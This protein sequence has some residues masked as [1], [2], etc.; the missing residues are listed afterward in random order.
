MS[1]KDLFNEGDASYDAVN[2]FIT[3]TKSEQDSHK[4]WINIL[5][6]TVSADNKKWTNV[7]E[8]RNHDNTPFVL[9]QKFLKLVPMQQRFIGN[10]A[11]SFFLLRRTSGS[12]FKHLISLWMFCPEFVSAFIP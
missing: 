1:K 6:H 2:L 8:L 12:P 4:C 7:D 11:F 9:R 10:I 3:G 5:N